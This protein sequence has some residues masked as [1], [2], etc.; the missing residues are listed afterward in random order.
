LT[1][2]RR[3]PTTKR[4]NPY[5]MTESMDK[6][7]VAAAKRVLVVDDE[8]GVR[9]MVAEYLARHGFVATTAGGGRELDAHFAQQR[10]DLVI[11]D[12]TMP[13]EDGIA[14]ARRLRA[15]HPTLP[16]IMLTALE[17]VV[18]RVVGLESGADDYITKPFDLRELR[19]RIQAVMRR[20]DGAARD[21][22][23]ATPADDAVAF[24][25]VVLD[26]KGRKLLHPDG[27][28][29]RLTAMEFD[30]LE[31]F[32]RHPN[33]V[34]SRSRLLDLAHN[35]EMEPF[36]RSIDIRITR[37]RRKIERDPAKPQVIKTERGVGYI[38]VTSTRRLTD[39][40]GGH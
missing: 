39:G 5:A 23:E 40:K 25:D 3:R 6:P 36:D 34:L 27:R 32:A 18:D 14:I 7:S 33:Q 19:A 22:A 38:F 15:A 13:E 1:A 24:G 10:P 9:Q 29:E 16:I 2:A 35:R 30:L 26:L 8:P 28:E 11:L 37:L 17:E 4:R 31:A 21:G 12:V 20:A